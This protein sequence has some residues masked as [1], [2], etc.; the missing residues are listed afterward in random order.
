[1]GYNSFA[2]NTVY[3]FSRRCLPNQRNHAKF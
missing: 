2:H 1:M 3:S